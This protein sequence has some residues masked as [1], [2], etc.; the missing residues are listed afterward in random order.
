MT[1]KL[2]MISKLPVTRKMYFR[3][4]MLALPLWLAGC[5]QTVTDVSTEGRGH[6][7]AGAEAPEKGPHGGRLLTDG[8]FAIELAIFESGVPPE[9]R[10][11]ATHKG[12]ALPPD[13]VR[14]SVELTR[15]DGEKNVFHFAPQDDFLRG[16]GVVTEPH[17]FDVVVIAGYAG[18]T[19]RWA[20][21]NYEGRVTIPAASAAGAGI[22]VETAGPRL[23]RD[24]LPL[25]G[26]I[27][28]NPDAVR[29]VGA[30]FPGEVRS[31]SK[32]VGD[33]VQA[34]DVLARV[35]SNDSLQVYAVTAPI[36]GTITARMTNPGQQ[37]GDS[38]LFRVSNLAQLWAELSVFP[39]DLARIRVGQPVRLRSL[40]GMLN[41]SGRIARIAPAG[42]DAS[43]ALLVWAAF[44]TGADGWTPGL[45]VNADV[46]AGGAEVPLA[47]RASGLQ[48]FRDFT[49]VFARVGETYEVRMLELGRGDGEYVEVLE[50]LKPGTEY[51]S[52]NSYLIKADIEKSGASHDH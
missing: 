11:W 21:E 52:E 27:A 3:I 44:D 24:L 18:T 22:A 17:S 51:V 12:Q 2:S 14:F 50:G 37:A 4:F 39:R 30:R 19:H 46:L 8:E 28:I 38:P 16:D 40:D 29:D 6:G 23:I 7:A 26:R 36:A 34:G 9:Y 20:Y 10:A 48:A 13:G 5:D 42:G 32:S 31:V 43:Q 15:L 49:V 25:Y 1:S 41:A 45:Y 47:V 33:T 35:E